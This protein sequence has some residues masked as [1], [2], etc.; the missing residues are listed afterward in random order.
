MF[1]WSLYKDFFSVFNFVEACLRLCITNIRYG[2]VC[3]SWQL[4]LSFA[5]VTINAENLLSQ[6]VRACVSLLA[7]VTSFDVSFFHVIGSDAKPF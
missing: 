5:N 1:K 7:D 4:E 2:R 6:T 3:V